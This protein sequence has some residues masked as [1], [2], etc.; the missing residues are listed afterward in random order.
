MTRDSWLLWLGI[1][2]AVI[3][4][5]AVSEAPWLWD[6]AD[7]M[8]FAALVVGIVSGKLATSPL[9]GENDAKKVD[10]TK[11]APLVVVALILPGLVGCA[12][13]FK[14]KLQQADR[15]VQSALF[16]LDQVENDAF[17]AGQVPADWHKNFSKQMVIALTAGQTFHRSVMAYQPGQKIPIDVIQLASALESAAELVRSL[18]PSETKAKIATVLD[19]AAFV[20]RNLLVLVLPQ[21][22]ADALIPPPLIVA[23]AEGGL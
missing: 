8:K 16:T 6:W 21:Q 3:G 5:L 14:A 7:W 18:P 2:G 15:S 13:S 12:P 4:Y 11:I 22:Q 10:L 1:A 23:P 17:K 20:A 19:T 9:A